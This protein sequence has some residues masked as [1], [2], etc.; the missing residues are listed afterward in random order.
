MRRWGAGAGAVAIA[1]LA[2]GCSAQEALSLNAP[3]G[4]TEQTPLIENLWFGAWVAVTVVGLVTGGLILY[5][6]IRFRRKDG[7]P[8]PKQLR[9]NVP[10]RADVHD[11]P[12]RHDPWHVLLHRA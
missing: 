11:R 10:A 5:A 7:D 6:A 4:A 9:Y 12:P 1:L 2:S 3:D 8:A